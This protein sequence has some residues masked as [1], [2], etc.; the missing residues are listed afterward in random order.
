MVKTSSYDKW[1][2]S[3]VWG[4]LQAL[5]W[6]YMNTRAQHMLLFESKTLYILTRYVHRWERESSFRSSLCQGRLHKEICRICTIFKKIHK[7]LD[8]P[9]LSITNTA[10]ICSTLRNSPSICNAA[11]VIPQPK[12]TKNGERFF[13]QR[14]YIAAH[15]S[16]CLAEFRGF[17]ILFVSFLRD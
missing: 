9:I 17:K 15:K 6:K 5:A 3:I 8:N 7:S 4:T 16:Y 12:S 10:T 11:G 2:G 13:R 1:R 14:S